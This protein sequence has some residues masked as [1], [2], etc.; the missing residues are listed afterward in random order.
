MRSTDEIQDWLN[1]HYIIDADR[2][3]I[4]KWLNMMYDDK[5]LVWD[6]LVATDDLT[7]DSTFE[8]LRDYFHAQSMDG[9]K[10][11]NGTGDQ[12][13]Q[14]VELSYENKIKE[15]I[16]ESKE[17]NKKV[18]ESNKRFLNAINEFNK[19]EKK[20]QSFPN[21]QVPKRF[22]K[23]LVKFRSLFPKKKSTNPPTSLRK[24]VMNFVLRR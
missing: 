24:R 20:W 22:D 11:N 23:L 1:I 18:I 8:D 14:G 2:F 9:P 17:L 12:G 7:I 21:F 5:M 6:V 4:S 16:R 13:A 3:Q 15:F 10:D 19:P